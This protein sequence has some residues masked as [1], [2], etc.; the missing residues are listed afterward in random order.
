MKTMPDR[1]TKRERAALR[2]LAAA[3][4]QQE[5]E[6]ALT[7]LYDAFHTW[8][9]KGMSAF[10]LNEKIHDFHNGLSRELYRIYVMNNPELAVTLGIARGTISLDELEEALREK[11][12]PL[13]ESVERID[14]PGND[15]AT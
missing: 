8:G 5:L 9:R 1:F 7:D 3:A 4:Y 6:D 13:S 14:R 15:G 10:E 12:R 11:L 2:D